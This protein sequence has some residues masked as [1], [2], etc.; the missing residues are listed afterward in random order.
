MTDQKYPLYRVDLGTPE[1]FGPYTTHVDAHESFVA[2]GSVGSIRRCRAIAASELHGLS[3]IVTRLVDDVDD[4]L[5]KGNL[6]DTAAFRP[7]DQVVTCPDA[8]AF[9]AALIKLFDEHL[10]VA[11]YVSEGDE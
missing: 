3:E 5:C 11:A 10:H 4:H 9:Q 2:R 8:V 7:E 6:P 1:L